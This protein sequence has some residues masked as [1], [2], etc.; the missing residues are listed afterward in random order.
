MW[1]EVYTDIYFHS[2]S[3]LFISYSKLHLAYGSVNLSK[4]RP[5]CNVVDRRE[6][7]RQESTNQRNNRSL[8]IMARKNFEWLLLSHRRN[9]NEEKLFLYLN[10][11]NAKICL[12]LMCA[13]EQVVRGSRHLEDYKYSLASRKLPSCE[14]NKTN[15]QERVKKYS[16]FLSYMV[17]MHLLWESG[18]ERDLHR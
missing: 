2:Y 15:I 12:C 10:L 8:L 3:F 14:M 5:S 13:Q 11:C 1:F 7:R 18:R 17:Q 6:T 4:C 16:Q 9:W